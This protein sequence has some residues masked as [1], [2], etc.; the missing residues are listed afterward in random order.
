MTPKEHLHTFT[1]SETDA[2][3]YMGSCA[4]DLCRYK[5]GILVEISLHIQLYNS[6]L[7]AEISSYKIARSI[8]L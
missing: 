7:T 6:L 5:I 4:R 8:C 1:P 3:L 2:D